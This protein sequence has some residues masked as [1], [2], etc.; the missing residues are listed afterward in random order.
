M[1]PKFDKPPFWERKEALKRA[2]V[3][4]IDVS[5]GVSDADTS[6]ESA[7]EPENPATYNIEYDTE[8]KEYRLR[9]SRRF[10]TREEQPKEE[11]DVEEFVENRVKHDHETYKRDIGNRIHRLTPDPDCLDQ[12]EMTDD[13]VVNPK[14]RFIKWGLILIVV[15]GLFWGAKSLWDKGP[16][17]LIGAVL[18]VL[19]ILAIIREGMEYGEGSIFRYLYYSGTGP[20]WF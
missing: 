14:Y 9:S 6:D 12:S 19:L 17:N 8:R 10:K 20:W 13:W 5:T 2:G 1:T 18:I 15:G 7:G 16:M 4:L 3:D 11:T